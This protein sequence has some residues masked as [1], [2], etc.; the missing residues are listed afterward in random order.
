[1]SPPT[2]PPPPRP[3]SR[4]LGI[5]TGR[6]PTGPLNAVTDV[7]GVRVGHTTVWSD[8][9]TGDVAGS[10]EGTG[11]ADTAATL[12]TGVTALWPHDGNPFTERVYAATSTFNGYG[13][14]TGDLVVDEWGLLGS[15]VVLCDTAN[16]GVAYDAVVRHLQ[17][18]DPSAGR[19]DVV[20]PVVGECDDGFLNDNRARALT[21]EHVVSALTAASTGAVAMGAVGAGTGMQLFDYKGGIGTASR[22]VRLGDR[23]WTVGVLLNGNF[24]T[25]AQLR[26]A[27]VP[28]GPALSDRMPSRH[29]EGSCIAV[30]ATDLPLLPHQL[31]RLARRVDVGLGRLGS[32]GNDGSGEIFLAFSTAARVPRTGDLLDLRAVVEGQY[33]THGSPLDD[34]FDAVA[35]AA[36]EAALDA[37]FVADTVHGRDGNVLH[38]L[39]LDEVLPLLGR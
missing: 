32:V 18:L 30:V 29:S 33:W 24:G 27:G 12:R 31:R 15:P 35:E 22:V 16:L 9:A 8:G 14:L 39:P 4:D 38:G 2:G 20:M 10:T 13:V 19:D 23:E 7:P 11:A 26:V 25:R 17:S 34:V 6:L 28:V 5:V 21:E 1:M 36:E 3:R 37:L